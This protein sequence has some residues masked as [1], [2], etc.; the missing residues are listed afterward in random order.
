MEEII[1]FLVREE[2]PNYRFYKNKIAGKK[3]KLHIDMILAL[4]LN[5]M[6]NALGNFEKLSI[7][8]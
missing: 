5:N 6:L 8:Y 1:K 2:N 3:N 4:H 7:I